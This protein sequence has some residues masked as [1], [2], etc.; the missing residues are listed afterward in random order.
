MEWFS[1]LRLG[2]KL[3]I[4]FVSCALITLIIG[5]LGSLGTTRLS[6]SLEQVFAHDLVSYAK[7]AEAKAAAISHN[8]DLYVV[9]SMTFGGAPKAEI[10]DTLTELEGYRKTSEQTIA[11]YRTLSLQADEAALGAPLQAQWS[12]Y[13]A[14]TAKVLAALAAGD[15]AGVPDILRDEF[16]PR[17]LQLM[18]TFDKLS[19][20]KN[21]QIGAGAEQASR[22]ADSVKSKLYAGIGIAFIVAIGLGLLITRSITAPIGVAVATARRIAEGD[23]SGV[24]HSSRRDEPGQLLQAL[25]RMQGQL[26]L[27][28]QEITGASKRLAT[29]AG[30]LD[31]ITDESAQ[32]TER[33]HDEIQQAATA[34]TEM[35]TA[36]EEVA[37]NAVSTSEATRNASQGAEIGRAR[38]QEA[39][40]AIDGLSQAL[41]SSSATVEQLAAQVSSIGSVVDVIRSIAEQTN[42]LALNAAIEAA[43]AGDQGRGFAVVADEVRALAARTQASTGEIERMIGGVQQS[44]VQA[45]RAMGDSQGL[46]QNTQDAAQLADEALEHITQTVSGINE[47]NLVIASAAEEQAQV[48]HE[49]DRNLNNIQQLSTQTAAVAQQTRQASK[50]LLQVTDVFTGLVARFRL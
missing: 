13:Q 22:T 20:L 33:Q 2:L 35:T 1:H 5:G 8:R 40:S 19:A 38:V 18:D 21:Q 39:A 17:Y 42:L 23:L 44:A 4:A 11:S 7:V 29:A 6:D 36:V 10:A 12:A 41:G 14:S 37:R 30:G 15:M 49:V 3:Q 32:G 45:V 34:V 16:F 26:K 31:R 28:L 24:I 9:L 47:R 48:A 43:R 50:E 46:I 25:E 27:T